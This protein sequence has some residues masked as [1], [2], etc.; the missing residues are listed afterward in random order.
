MGV[1]P[2]AL[3]NACR[4]STSMFGRCAARNFQLMTVQGE[5]ESTS[6]MNGLR[7]PILLMISTVLKIGDADEVTRD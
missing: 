6:A 3:G 4:E 1:A 7:L 2:Q 5:F